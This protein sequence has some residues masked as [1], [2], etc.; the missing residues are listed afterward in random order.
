MP[1]AWFIAPYVRRDRAGIPIRACLVHDYAEQ[2]RAN[3]G[4]F[5]TIEILG[6]HALVKVRA[7]QAILD[8]GAAL[9]GVDRLSKDR[10]D[11]P[12]SDLS[13]AVKQ[14]LRDL[15]EELGYSLQEIND[16]F[17]NDLGTYT[18]GDVLRFLATRW[19]RPY[20]DAPTDTILFEEI[21]R[22]PPTRLDWVA[23]GVQ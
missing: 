20:Y 14:R 2:I 19:R 11:D 15:A 17:P 18:L 7:P 22:A 1:I 5:R 10:L 6:N 8:A 9:P 3:G 4:A 13:P 23:D 12:L 16:R 21:D